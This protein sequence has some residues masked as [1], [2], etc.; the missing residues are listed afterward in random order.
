[1]S[2]EGDVNTLLGSTQA[3]GAGGTL[4]GVV[5]PELGTEE[6]IIEKTLLSIQEKVKEIQK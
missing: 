3:V 6:G 1:M 4:G 2:G 5:T